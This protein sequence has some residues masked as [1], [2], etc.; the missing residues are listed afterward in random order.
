MNSI[1]LHI[2]AALAVA[3][4]D[5]QIFM[6]Y[7]LRLVSQVLS[8]LFAVTLFYYVSRLVTAITTA[9]NCHHWFAR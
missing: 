6:S 9:A 4:R 5:F 1:R 2:T 3:R 8:T 7:R